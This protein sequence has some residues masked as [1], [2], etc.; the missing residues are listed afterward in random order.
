MKRLTLKLSALLLAAFLVLSLTISANAESV[1]ALVTGIQKYGNLE[2]DLKGS[3]FLNAG[4]AYGDVVTVTL[5]GEEYEMPVGSNY[6]DVDNGAMLCRVVI[7]EET[8]EDATLLAINMGDLATTAG[9]AVKNSIEA[10][11]GFEWI[12]NEGVEQPVKV[13]IEMKEPGGYY[14]EYLIHQLTRSEERENYPD[15]SDE[16]FANFRMIATSGIRSGVLYRSSSPINP[17]IGRSALADAAAAEAGIKTIVNLADNDETMRGYEGFAESYYAKQNVI[18]LNLGVDFTAADFKAG[19]AKALRF[20]AENDGPYLIHCNEGKDRAGF[21]SAIVEALMGAPAD[22]I[23][24][25]YMTTFHNYYGVEEGTEQYDAVVNSNISKSL[26]TAFGVADIF[27]PDVD[28]KAEAEEYLEEELGLTAEE[29]AAIKEK[30]QAPS[31]ST[32]APSVDEIDK[33][34]DVRLSATSGELRQ[35]GVEYADYVHVAFSG[36]VLKLPVVPDYRYVEAKGSAL[37]VWEDDAKPVELE[38]FN[39]SFAAT[40]GLADKTTNEDKTYFWTAQEGVE[41]PVKVTVSQGEK[42]GY[43]DQYLLYDLNRTNERGD[44]AALTDEEFANFR[45]VTTSGMGKNVLYRASSPV[46]PKI[47]RSAFADAAVK[48]AEI[49]T[50]MNQADNEEAANAYEGFADTY[51]ASQNVIYL[52]LGADMASDQNRAGFAEGLRFFIA[53]D[54]PYLIHCNEGQDRTGFSVAIL[55]CLMGASREEV[56]ADYM[57]TFENFYGVEKGS[58]QYNAISNNIIKNL[59]TAFAVN[60][61]DG[62]DLTEAAEAYLRGIGL[63]DEEITAL[64]EKLGAK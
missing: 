21:F 8:S 36:Q 1:E 44:Y 64:K 28:L 14:E 63:R 22:E 32:V 4:F 34:G 35:F 61:L 24:A 25:D 50:I 48:E 13:T 10:D 5:N 43:A 23:V 26:Q 27:A 16:E 60:S 37:V 47:G 31:L 41:F 45:A 15:L 6:S 30:L 39:G 42:G 3:D 52:A 58:E 12:Y 54:G 62:L 9:I 11:P 55:E 18:G 29:I 40:Y 2:L 57:K 17:E 56:V 51:T 53:N 38:I 33:Y 20:I 59:K 7:K 19:L 46:N 49:K